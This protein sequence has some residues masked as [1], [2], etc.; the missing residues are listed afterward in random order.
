MCALIYKL[1][2]EHILNKLLQTELPKGGIWLEDYSKVLAGKP[3]ENYK[4]HFKI[5]FEVF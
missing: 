3:S 2:E 1:H 5:V 4:A